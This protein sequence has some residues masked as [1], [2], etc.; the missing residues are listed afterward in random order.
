MNDNPNEN[1]AK[2]GH[3]AY[4]SAVKLNN[5]PY[6]K[7]DELLVKTSHFMAYHT[8][9]TESADFTEAL[10]YAKELS[11]NISEA[12]GQEVFPYSVFYVYY[13]QFLTTREHTWKNLL[14]CVTAIFVVTFL[15]LGFNIS[16]AACVTV[17]VCMIVVNLIGWM[18]MWDVSLNAVSLVNLVMSV[19]ISVE[20]CSHVVRAFA[21][22]SKMTR[23]ERAEDALARVG[24]SIL[25]GITLTKFI[26]VFV[27]MFARTQLFVVYYFRMFTGIIVLGATHGI[28]FLPVLLSY[29]GPPRWKGTNTEESQPTS[30]DAVVI[31]NYAVAGVKMSIVEEKSDIHHSQYEK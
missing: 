13:E 5:V 30:D 7:T 23:V 24:S 9:L 21:T 22:S 26:G 31:E 27:L 1:C 6:K 29:V 11:A 20:F 14:I 16:S 2:A 3:A 10:R 4:G 15:L 28:I 8:V 12:I 19:G 17:T 18:Y 25:S